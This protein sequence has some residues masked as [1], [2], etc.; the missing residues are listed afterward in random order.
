MLRLV[1]LRIL[2]STLFH[3]VLV[4]RKKETAHK[5]IVPNSY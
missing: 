2:R 1:E 3:S 5:I 4:D